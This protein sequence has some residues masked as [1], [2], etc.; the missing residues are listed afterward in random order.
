M[1]LKERVHIDGR[2]VQLSNLDKV[3]WPGPGLTKAD[4]LAYHAHL[5]PC[6]LPHWEGRLLTVTRYPKGVEESFFY[7]KN[8]PAGAPQ[9]VQTIRRK[10]T[11]YVV[12][13]HLSTVIWL[14]NSNA[15]E[16]HPSL[17]L[18]AQS[19]VP[20]YAVIDLD[21]TP[22]AGFSEAV[23]IAKHCRD[24][25]DKLNLQGYPKLSGATG[26]HIYIPLKAE[27]TFAVAQK[28]IHLI[29]QTLK[30]A[31]PQLITLERLVKNRRGIYVDY[32]QNH[33]EKTIV[34]V[35]SPR[36]TPQAT[37][38]TPVTWADL[39]Y[40]Q[41]QD[42]TIATVPQWVAEKGD[43]FSSV[44]ENPQALEHLCAYLV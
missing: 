21:P 15:I 33:Q 10:D 14:A 23:Q 40:Y 36:S 35:Y 30:R 31:F 34:G 5:R 37:V 18:A 9:W 13:D 42:F 38:S 3:L 16:F 26:L 1:V 25:L 11:E 22:P 43:L 27:Y 12:A 41:P 28:L 6:L 29:A 7:Q 2:T 17:D 20:S 32:L 39:N 24:L 8:V 44:I 19:G 4:L